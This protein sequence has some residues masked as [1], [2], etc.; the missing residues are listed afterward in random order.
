MPRSCLIAVGLLLLVSSARS[1]EPTAAEKQVATEYLRAVQ[2][3]RTKLHEAGFVLG[4]T[5]GPLVQQAKDVDA[6][7]SEAKY[8]DL[9][10]TLAD[11]KKNV[12]SK[13]VPSGESGEG[14]DKAWKAFAKT[15]TRV[16]EIEMAAIIAIL[17]DRD[18]DNDAKKAQIL[19]LIDRIV[20]KEKKDSEGL[21]AAQKELVT[22]F[23]IST[24]APK[25]P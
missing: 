16:I 4:R 22:A 7:E 20:A 5:I 21:T 9:K 18:S 11:I 17:D 8:A 19:R 12:A 15:Q 1:A 24:E 10:A 14:I 3:A 25:Q 23:G 13:K 2:E 6:A